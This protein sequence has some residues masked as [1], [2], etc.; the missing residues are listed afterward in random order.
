MAWNG[1]ELNTGVR[2]VRIAHGGLSVTRMESIR[3]EKKI[4]TRFNHN[5]KKNTAQRNQTQCNAHIC[6]CFNSSLFFQLHYGV[7][8]VSGFDVCVCLFVVFSSVNAFAHFE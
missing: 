7:Y 2:T 8:S 5:R 1:I 6:C 4:E 3:N